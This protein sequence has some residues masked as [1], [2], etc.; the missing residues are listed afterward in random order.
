MPEPWQ[1][2]N[3]APVR[4]RYLSYDERTSERFQDYE[5]RQS[6]RAPEEVLFALANRPEF[7]QPVPPHRTSLQQYAFRFPALSGHPEQRITGLRRVSPAEWDAAAVMPLSYE[8][9]KPEGPYFAFYN[10]RPIP[11]AGKSFDK[12]EN[13]YWEMAPALS[14]PSGRRLAVM[15]YGP[16]ESNGSGEGWG[17]AFIDWK[18]YTVDLY[19]VANGQRIGRVRIWGCFSSG[20][21]DAEWHGDTIFTVPRDESAQHFIIC[22]LH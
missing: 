6:P 7:D 1:Y 22:G 3:G 21:N 15:S 14:S 10:D 16:H 12:T 18:R 5:F 8:G 17:R 19:H 2:P 13:H 11:Y 4:D 20:L 9:L